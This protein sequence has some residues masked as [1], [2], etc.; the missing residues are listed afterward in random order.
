MPREVTIEQRI[1]EDEQNPFSVEDAVKHGNEELQASDADA[2]VKLDTE[3]AFTQQCMC[4][5]E[6][7]CWQKGK[8]AA[9]QW[10]KQQHARKHFHQWQLRV[11]WMMRTECNNCTMDKKCNCTIKGRMACNEESTEEKLKG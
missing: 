3:F 6:T 8:Q 4:H 11:K 7:R 1:T 2:K 9:K 10:L 5:K